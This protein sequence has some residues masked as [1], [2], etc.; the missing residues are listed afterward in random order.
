MRG[1]Y[2]KKYDRTLRGRYRNGKSRAKR[3]DISWSIT[4]GEYIEILSNNSC[5]YCD[6]V[7]NETGIAL[8]RMDNNKGYM[9]TNVVACCNVCNSLKSD[10][11]THT[12]M[13]L[14]AGMLK[15]FRQVCK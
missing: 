4:M 3:K 11:L 1:H 15:L 8:D 7:L 2:Y 14:V 5:F 10:K 6:G 12:E 13:I 9:T